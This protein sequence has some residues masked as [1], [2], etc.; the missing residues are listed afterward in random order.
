MRRTPP[1]AAAA[2]DPA[3][4]PHDAALDAAQDFIY[5][6]WEITSAKRRIALA[7]QALA[8]RTSDAPFRFAPRCAASG[9]RPVGRGYGR[10]GRVPRR[11]ITCR[12]CCGSTRTTIRG[13]VTSSRPGWSKATGTTRS[14]RCSRPTRTKAGP[15]GRGRGRRRRSGAAA[16]ARRAARCYCW[17]MIFSENRYPPRI[18]SGAGFF[19]IM[20]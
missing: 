10:A 18:K 11:S 14:P 3:S 15:S 16:T 19:G 4:L 13:S 5:D 8:P 20:L 2:L 1:K 6:A 17:S 12:R 9:A 7:R